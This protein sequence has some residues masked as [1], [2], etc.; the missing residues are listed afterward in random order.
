MNIL[1]SKFFLVYESGILLFFRFE[2]IL[3]SS[4][5]DKYPLV[6][7]KREN[8]ALRLRLP[9]MFSARV[10][11]SSK[12]EST[13]MPHSSDIASRGE[14]PVAYPSRVSY[15]PIISILEGQRRSANGLGE[16]AVQEKSF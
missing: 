5:E 4:V 10:F 13:I 6:I 2:T 12:Q 7:I 3:F 16:S 14:L 9:L 15:H 11:L 8:F 1:K